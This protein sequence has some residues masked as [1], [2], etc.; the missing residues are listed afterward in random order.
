MNKRL[1]R[2]NTLLKEI[3]AEVVI[4]E[5]RNPKLIGVISIRRVEITPDLHHAQVYIGIIASPLQQKKTLSILQSAAG[6]ISTQAS[7]KIT[8][9]YF[10]IL[11]F[12]IDPTLENEIRVHQILETI[13]STQS[14]YSD[15]RRN[16]LDR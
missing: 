4:Y 10:P 5:M 6:F 13:N 15:E 7:K 8:L 9:R 16:P 14:A 3:I 2:L 1:E 11:H 12:H